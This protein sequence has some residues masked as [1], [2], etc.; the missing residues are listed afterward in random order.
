MGFLVFVGMIIG[1][2]IVGKKIYEDKQYKD[3]DHSQ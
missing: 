2:C 1:A 3:V